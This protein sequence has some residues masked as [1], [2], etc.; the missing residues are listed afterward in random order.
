VG[1]ASGIR[2]LPGGVEEYLRLRGGERDG[3][4]EGEGFARPARAPSP[5]ARARAARRESRRGELELKRLERA[6]ERVA[7]REGALG[8]EMEANATD[9]AR[10]TEL[11]GELARLTA[12]REGFES[13]WLEL[14]E[15]LES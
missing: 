7:E 6:I 4:G 12:E 5:G 11:Q 9:H 8:E 1:G 2:H 10:L 15:A 14:S 3:G 13:A